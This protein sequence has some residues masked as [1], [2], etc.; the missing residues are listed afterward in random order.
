[1]RINLRPSKKVCYLIVISIIVLLLD[2]LTKIFADNLINLHE[3]DPVIPGFLN[4]TLTYNRGIAFGLFANLSELFRII[5]LVLATSLMLIGV[6]FFL[7]REYSHNRFGILALGFI[8]G[9]AIGNLYDRAF[10][11]H[12]VDFID[13]YY[14]NYHWPA[15]NIADSAICVGVC[16]LLI[17]KPLKKPVDAS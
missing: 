15:F 14:K 3:I 8:L 9:G 6:L 17:I 5:I 12:V 11:G 16:L 10:N 4:F 2:Q 7:W 13:I 1:M